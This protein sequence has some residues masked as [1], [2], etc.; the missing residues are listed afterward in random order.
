MKVFRR[1]KLTMTILLVAMVLVLVSPS[2]AL[3]QTGLV[4]PSFEAGDLSGWDLTIPSGG[5]AVA[6][7]SYKSYEA[8]DGDFFALV[9]TN[10]S[11]L[12]TIVSQTFS[13]CAGDKI[14]GW[15]FFEAEDYMF[16]NDNTQVRIKSGST[17]LDTVFSASVSTVGDYG[18]TPWTYWQYT[19]TAAGTYTVEALIANFVDAGFDSHM[20][21]DAVVLTSSGPN[22]VVPTSSGPKALKQDAIDLLSEH[23]G[24]SK[25]IDKAIKH[26]DK[27]LDEKLWVDGTQL[28]AKHGAKVFNE[29]KKAVKELMHLLKKDNTSEEVKGVC[30]SV[31]DK[32]IEADDLLAH[33]AYKE[34]SVYTGNPKVDKELEKFDK[35]F[36]KG[37]KEL[38]HTKKDGTPDPKYDK[39][40]KHYKNAWKHAQKALG[41]VPE[42]DEDGE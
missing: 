26:L 37:Q 38:D 21:L 27:S 15:A 39:A 24:E 20:G 28:V 6:A 34:A 1:A 8:E 25:H 12:R 4:N 42:D 31:I 36:E 3:A 9:K 41:K 10:G 16:F 30:Q 23:A 14:S 2:A 18:A 19:F 7:T 29:E 11:G 40:I 35:E 5:S 33:A 13:A 22:A 32:L 17:V